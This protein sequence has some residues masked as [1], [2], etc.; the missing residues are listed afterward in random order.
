[1][2]VPGPGLEPAPQQ[3]QRQILTADHWGAFFFFFFRAAPT[4]YGGSQA[5]GRI[6]ATAAGWLHSPGNTGSEP[7]LRPTPQLV[8]MPGC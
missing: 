2:E 8:A 7:P 4:E 6:R 3:R 1:M 5:R